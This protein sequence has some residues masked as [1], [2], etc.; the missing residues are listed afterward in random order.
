MSKVNI[1]LPRMG[2]GVEEATLIEYKCAVGDTL[3]VDDVIAEIATDKVDTE[4]TTHVGGVVIELLFKKDDVIR[5]G[6]VV[7]VIE[8]GE[9]EVQDSVD[10]VERG[11]VIDGGDNRQ[12]SMVDDYA[13]AS[14]FYSPLVRR[15]ARVEG[16][17]LCELE[18]VKGTGLSGRVTKD[19]ILAYVKAGRVYKD[20]D[21]VETVADEVIPMSRMRRVIAQNM[22]NSI[23]ASAHAT[24]FSMVDVTVLAQW[25]KRIKEEFEGKYGEHLTFTPIFMMAVASA[26]KD[27][28]MI[29]SQVDGENII[30]HKDINIGMA[31]A[32]QEGELI[33]PVIRRADTLTLPQMASKVNDLARRAREGKLLPME[34][35]GGTFTLTNVGTFG[36]LF[37]TPIINQ[38]Q[39]A[40]LAIGTIEKVPAV[41]SVDGI[42]VV[43]VREKTYLSMSYD[44]RVIDGGAAGVFMKRVTD[45]LSLWDKDKSIG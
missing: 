44:H 35:T 2:Q 21:V 3:A 39:V 28:P 12:D 25:R 31:V 45:Y 10:D 36:T 34:V 20:V 41:I 14:R 30:L 9:E 13:G 43:A 16:I 11:T 8:T 5:V 15:V 4:I 22:M 42:D 37:G 32:T 26:L 7:A 24:S 33:V 38:P 17:S 23:A 6:E 29:N 18:K 27:C 19:D 40:I 1:I